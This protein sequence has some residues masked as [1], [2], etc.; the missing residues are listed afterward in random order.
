[1]VIVKRI[2]PFGIH[3]DVVKLLANWKMLI[4]NRRIKKKWRNPKEYSNCKQ[5]HVRNEAACPRVQKLECIGHVKK[6]MGTHLRE[7]RNKHTKPKDGKS[8]K[9][10]NHKLID[11]A[12]EK[13]QFIMVMQS[14]QM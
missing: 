12:V 7:L 1:M 6:R 11:R 3:I 9:G 2:T 10:C 4:S 14:G 13:L 5:V 8:V